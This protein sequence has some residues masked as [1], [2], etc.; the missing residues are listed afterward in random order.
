MADTGVDFILRTGD[1]VQTFT[2]AGGGGG[3]DFT[4]VLNGV[5]SGVIDETDT[6]AQMQT[7]LEAMSNITAGDVTV[8]G[9][10]GGPYVLTWAQNFAGLYPN[11]SVGS[12]TG[13]MTVTIANSGLT[14]ITTLAGGR[15]DSL[16]RNSDEADITTKSSGGWHEGL[17][18]LRNWSFEFSHALIESDAAL[19][20]WS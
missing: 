10:A 7:I 18:T 8:T 1:S 5:T 9:A 13:A 11:T 4:V 15:S 3:D 12:T 2:T 19:R 20:P 17:P 6:G 14:N 16:T